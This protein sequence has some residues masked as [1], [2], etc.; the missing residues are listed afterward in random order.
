MSLDKILQQN[1]VIAIL[2]A[3]DADRFG[4]VT[5][6]VVDAGVRA[7]EF[8]LTSA[9]ALNAIR[10]YAARK[11]DDVAL[12]AGTVLTPDDARQAVEAGA[13]FLIAPVVDAEVIGEANRLGVPIVPGAF[14]PTE[15]HA[16]WRAGAYAVK[17]FPAGSV[18]P[19]YLKAVKGP[20]P[21]VPLVPTGNV[22][23]A[24]AKAFLDAGAIAVGV[25]GPLIGDATKPGG[26]LGALASRARTLVE[27]VARR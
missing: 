5:D 20:L 14:S 18:G 15:I 22:E 8:T 21:D 6:V 27:S 13:S 24:D 11:P 9:N 19:E 2:R 17:V 23:I 16:A 12:G 4:E 3:P 25:G 1:P 10:S 7:V 26:D